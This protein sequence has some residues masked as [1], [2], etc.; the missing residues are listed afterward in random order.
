MGCIHKYR[1]QELRRQLAKVVK[2]RP[3]SQKDLM[4][5]PTDV[6]QEQTFA[7]GFGVWHAGMTATEEVCDRLFSVGTGSSDTP[8]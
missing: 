1:H 2:S 8:G 7:E 6:C 3:S 5:V 4:R